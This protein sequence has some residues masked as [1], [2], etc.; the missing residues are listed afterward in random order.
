MLEKF[1]AS[2]FHAGN[3]T[4][5]VLYILERPSSWSTSQIRPSWPR[6]RVR[7]CLLQVL[8][9]QVY[10]C[11][12][13][14]TQYLAVCSNGSYFELIPFLADWLLNTS[15]QV[16]NTTA[17]HHIYTDTHIYI[18][19]TLLFILFFKLLPLL[20]AG[21]QPLTLPVRHSTG[22][23]I[24]WSWVLDALSWFGSCDMVYPPPPRH[25]CMAMKFVSW[26]VDQVYP[27]QSTMSIH[28]I[29]CSI[30]GCVSVKH[31]KY[32]TMWLCSFVGETFWNPQCD[33]IIVVLCWNITVNHVLIRWG[34]CKGWV[35]RGCARSLAGCGR[36]GPYVAV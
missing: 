1:M 13:W 35:V 34:K 17:L 28:M 19:L 18:T 11:L 20:L 21:Q 22:N 12:L 4:I 6:S 2:I 25:T 10:S 8:F 36:K 15:I 23:L 7:L 24:T 27:K 32:L 3:H 30:V 33:V 14:P 29:G 31:Y 9:P 5:I 16:N 26:S